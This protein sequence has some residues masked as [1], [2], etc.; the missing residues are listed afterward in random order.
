MATKEPRGRKA[1]HEECGRCV[2]RRAGT[3]LV[4]AITLK[5]IEMSRCYVTDLKLTQRHIFASGAV[6]PFSH[7]TPTKQGRGLAV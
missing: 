7:L 2:R 4:G 5:A 1:Q 3:G 6:P